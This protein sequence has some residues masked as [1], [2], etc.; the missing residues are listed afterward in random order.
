MSSNNLYVYKAYVEQVYDGDTI[1]CTI[2]CG[3]G[4]NCKKQKVRLYG[5]NTLKFEVIKKNLE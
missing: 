3:F 1:T 4:I 2:D 5:I